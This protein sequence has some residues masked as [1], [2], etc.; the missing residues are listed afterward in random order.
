MNLSL[1]KALYR[2]VIFKPHYWHPWTSEPSVRLYK[3][4]A[5]WPGAL[6]AVW[7]IAVV[8]CTPVRAHL[9]CDDPD[10][11]FGTA[12]SDMTFTNAFVVRNAGD[13]TLRLFGVLATCGCTVTETMPETL[14]PGE[15][16]TLTVH[17]DLRN[18]FGPQ[19]F[20]LWVRTDHPDEPLLALTIRGQVWRR[21]FAAPAPAPDREPGSASRA[22]ALI[23]RPA[24]VH[25]EPNQPGPQRRLLVV[26]SPDQTPFV[27]EQS[28]APPGVELRVQADKPFRWIVAV[29]VPGD[30]STAAL[31]QTPLKL[32][33][34]PGETLSIPFKELAG[35][36]P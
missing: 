34:L 25:L 36:R 7:W 23:V 4:P 5:R 10:F 11:D 32:Q 24:A 2:I 28:Q 22:P 19:R 16:A 1:V 30:V 6:A 14:A 20:V 13:R 29:T 27:I 18:R 12:S 31:V 35:P 3:R 15:Q 21:D 17:T 33:V 26:E 8:L 9:I